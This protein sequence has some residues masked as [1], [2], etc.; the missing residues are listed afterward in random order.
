METHLAL[1]R[2]KAMALRRLG[3]AREGRSGLL[4]LLIAAQ[5]GWGIAISDDRASAGS[6]FQCIEEYTVTVGDG[7]EIWT[8]GISCWCRDETGRHPGLLLWL[9]PAPGDWGAA[10]QRWLPELK[11]TPLLK[12]ETIAYWCRTQRRAICLECEA[13]LLTLLVA[14]GFGW[15]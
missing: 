14:H 11:T 15:S 6:C 3:A 2:A 5:S 7:E 8:T 13:K 10:S 4:L 1:R 12:L 9:V